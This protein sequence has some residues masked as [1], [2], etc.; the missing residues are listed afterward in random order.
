MQH[1]TTSIALRLMDVRSF[2][3]LTV[4]LKQIIRAAIPRRA[5]WSVACLEVQLS[6]AGVRRMRLR[7]WSCSWYILVLSSWWASKTHSAA[8]ANTQQSA[9]N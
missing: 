1:A 7:R 2:L 3:E 9:T 8:E 6:G 4:V 5:A